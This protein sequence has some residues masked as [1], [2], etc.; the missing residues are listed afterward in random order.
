MPHGLIRG[1]T[2]GWRR[3]FP[4]VR[5][6]HL[7]DGDGTSLQLYQL[8]PGTR[9]DLHAHNFPELGMILSGRGSLVLDG[10]EQ[11]IGAGDSFYLPGRLRHGFRVPEKGPPVLV[12]NVEA[13]AGTAVGSSFAREIPQRA[14]EAVR[15]EANDRFRD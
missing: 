12:F 14:P 1:P 8:E 6:R 11:S 3:L 13:A 9:L 7:V 10:G 2:T 4:G 15:P 5:V